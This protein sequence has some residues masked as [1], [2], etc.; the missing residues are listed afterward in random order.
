MAVATFCCY[1]LSFQVNS[2]FSPWV[3]Y[4]PGASLVF[5]PAG[6]KLVALLVAG[7]WGA[8]GLAV[9]AVLMAADVWTAAGAY[10][11]LGNI[12]VWL[13]VPYMIIESVLRIQG[14]KRD[15]SNLTFAPLLFITVAATVVGSAASSAYAVFAHGRKIDDYLATASAMAV[16]DFVGAGLMLMLTISALKLLKKTRKQNF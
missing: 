8:L 11:L 9:A 10:E 15:L 6:V 14:V 7:G 2:L 13:G 3:E 12:V 4:A 16:G 5:L 1:L